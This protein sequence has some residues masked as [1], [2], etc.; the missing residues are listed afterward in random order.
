MLQSVM[1]Q[2]KCSLMIVITV[3][4]TN[5]ETSVSTGRMN[6]SVETLNWR[7]HRT[8]IVTAAVT[9]HA[10]LRRTEEEDMMPI[11]QKEQ[12]ST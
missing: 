10:V 7:D 8:V 5:V 6:V 2:V 11:V 1:I 4:A 9:S 12:F 3:V